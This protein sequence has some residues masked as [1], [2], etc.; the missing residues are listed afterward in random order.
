MASNG[1]PLAI[2]GAGTVGS[3]LAAYLIKAGYE[4]VAIVDLSTVR[5]GLY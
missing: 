3:M 4:D 5:D 1:T 2:I